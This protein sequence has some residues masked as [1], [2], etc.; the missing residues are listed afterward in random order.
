MK[1]MFLL[2]SSILM[3][4]FLV[5]DN[6]ISKKERNYASKLL[7]DTEKGVFEQVKGLTEAQLTFKPAPDRWSVEECV[8]HIAASEEMM[9]QM[10]DGTLKQPANPE[11][12]TEIKFTDEQLV[13]KIED[14][15]NKVKTVEKL[16]PENIPLK[17]TEEALDAFKKNREKLIDYVKSTNEDLRAH[18][19]TMP[20][21]SA[22]SYQLL[23]FIGAHS[24]RHT[25]Q[26]ME[27][28]AD[29]NFPK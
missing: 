1:K 29:P 3:L 24:N 6:T 11:K 8:K 27:V 10:V 12:K 5:S 14:R 28:K 15:S 17:N 4:S 7:K 16:Q 13:Q 9:W 23:L 25:Q 26:I 19:A 20:F 18:I 2:A 21:G 22:D